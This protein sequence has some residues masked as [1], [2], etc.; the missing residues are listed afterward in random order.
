MKIKVNLTESSYNKILEDIRLFKIS[1]S[2]K[3]INKNKFINLLFKNFYRMYE[4]NID[5][6]INN[7]NEVVNDESLSKE[8]AL[9]L[10]N[11]IADSKNNYFNKS[12]TFILNDD[13]STSFEYIEEKLVYVSA[14][15]YFRN[16]IMEYLS[17]PQYKREEIIYKD[18]A[19]K[20]NEAI[21]NNNYL[22]FKVNDQK[23]SFRPYKLGTS[24]EEVYSY[25][26]GMTE[27]TTVRSYN[28]ANIKDIIIKRDKF[29]FEKKDIDLLEENI[30]NGIQFP[31]SKPYNTTIRLTERGKETFEKRYVNRPIPIEVNGNEYKFSCSFFQLKSYFLAFGHDAYIMG[32]R[33]REEINKEYSDAV[34]MY[35][36]RHVEK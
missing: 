7:I 9:K 17:Y 3:T 26:L 24:K 5:R 19:D 25:L 14:S 16:M 23:I 22:Q 34:N 4:D 6:T 30:K 28:L 35:N 27:G 29:E 33:L 13:N 21:A 32:S 1:K 36:K 20:I 2:D 11:D 12:L 10:Q 18:R 8:I 15:A 31:Y